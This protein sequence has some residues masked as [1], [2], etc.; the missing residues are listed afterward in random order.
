MLAG[1]RV[2]TPGWLQHSV[3]VV[4]WAVALSA[5]EAVLE[6]VDVGD[7]RP[8]LRFELSKFVGSVGGGAEEGTKE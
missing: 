6:G 7:V 1:R 8:G 4:G 2:G 5:V 3:F